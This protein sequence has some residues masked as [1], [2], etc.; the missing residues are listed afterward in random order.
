MSVKQ[1]LFGGQPAGGEKIKGKG[2]ESEYN[3]STS[4]T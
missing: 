1:G 3:Q 2:K 4:Y